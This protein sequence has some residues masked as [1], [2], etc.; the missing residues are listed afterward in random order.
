[1]S[2]NKAKILR[3]VA[4]GLVVLLV[5]AVLLVHFGPDLASKVFAQTADEMPGAVRQG[6]DEQ[7]MVQPVTVDV[8]RAALRDSSSARS[9]AGRVEPARTVDIAFQVSGQLSEL[10]VDAGDQVELGDVIAALDPVDFELAVDRAQAS[11]DLSQSE[12]DRA[13]SLSERGVATDARLDTTR[14]QLAQAEVALREARRRLSQARIVAPFDAIVARSFVEEFSNVTPAIPIVR[15]Q[16]ISEMRIRISLPEE[17][18]AMARV[19]PDAFRVIATFPSVPGYEATLF[20]RTFVTDADPTAQ[21]Y[22]VEF[23][24]EGDID[25]RLLPGMTANVRVSTAAEGAQSRSVVVPISAVDTTSQSEPSIWL[26]H[27]ETG[28]VSRTTIRLGLPNDDEIVVLEGLSG[29]ELVVSGG[30]WRLNENET[31]AVRGL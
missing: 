26:Y 16:D 23:L 20:P 31:V 24:I 17:L 13:L 22:D 28:R 1:M 29:D 15:L 25:P 9:L 12:Y 4:G 8:S 2:S 14:A 10:A 19:Q 21:T 11:F 18:A 5:S 30:W 3:G 6:G 27:E 7:E